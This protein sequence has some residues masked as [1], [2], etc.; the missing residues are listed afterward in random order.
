MYSTLYEFI[1]TISNH[2][3]NP[4]AVLESAPTIKVSALH[5]YSYCARL[6]YLE[7]V[8]SLYA[9]CGGICGEEVASGVGGNGG[10]EW[11]DL[12]LESVTLGLQGRVD[13]LRKRVAYP[14][15]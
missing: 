3:S 4:A 13:A 15:P 10:W 6:F 2:F 8:E 9:G 11:E 5:A 7:E 1:M 12:F 14:H